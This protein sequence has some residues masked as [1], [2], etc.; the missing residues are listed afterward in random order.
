[1]RSVG[2]MLVLGLSLSACPPT[3]V[4]CRPGTGRCGMGCADF[5]SDN[6][7]CGACGQA[8]AQGQVCVEGGCRCQQGTVSCAGQCVVV[9]NDAAN[10]GSC[11]RSCAAAEFCSA[12]QCV[13][14]CPDGG[15]ACGFSC[16]EVQTSAR[17][18]G[19]CGQ[20]CEA[21]QVCRNGQCTHDVV[22]ACFRSGQLVGLTS[23]FERGALRD[24]GNGPGA[25]AVAGDSVLSLDGID[26]VMYQAVASSNQANAILQQ[27]RR[28]NATGAVP[29]QAL[30][31]GMRIY[32]ANASSGT[33]QVLERGA[34]G[35]TEADAGVDGGLVLGTVAEVALG[36]NTF[37]QGV[38]RAA[39]HL[40]VPLYGGTDP[41]GI[42]AG[43][44]VMRLS[45]PGLA[46][47]GSF[48]LNGLDLQRFDGG[49][50]GYPRPWA[51]TARGDGV[52]VVLNNLTS[53]YRPAGPGLL[54]RIDTQTLAVTAIPLG[55][56]CLNPQW[57][58]PVGANLVVSCAGAA[59]YDSSFFA[60][61]SEG[62][63]VVLLGAQNTLQARWSSDCAADA[64]CTVFTPGRFAV[65]NGRVYVG[66]QNSGR[67]AVLDISDGGITPI[68]AGASAVAVCPAEMGTQLANVSDVIALP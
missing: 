45:L 22:A 60:N 50:L 59:T 58:A 11:G 25:L 51:I 34:V 20:A 6:R 66:D 41:A 26:N 56:T 4:V 68:R 10:C 33:V 37:P 61:A 53:D 39:D 7:N 9:E 52:Y 8:C 42:S 17:N 55:A 12:G 44:R 13:T 57:A 43:Q 2:L 15:S 5:S 30:V 27:R 32:I 35:G 67:L 21:G 18:C 31:D 47:A 64:G 24:V 36:A 1:M 48:S 54:A 38:V 46:D 49:A 65:K 23:T 62:S 63:G 28:Q 3:G 19:A 29:N 14:S 16:V 40:W